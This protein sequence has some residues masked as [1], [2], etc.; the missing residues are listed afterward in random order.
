MDKVFWLHPNVIAGRTGPNK[1]FWEPKELAK[2]GIGAVLSVNSGEGANPG[3]LADA[4]IRYACVPLSDAAPP[5]PGDF[6]ICTAALPQ[7]L[8]FA[9]R[10]IDSGKSLL[11]HCTSGKDRTAMFLSYYLCKTEGLAP[12]EAIQAVKQVRPIALTAKG[13]EALTLQVLDALGA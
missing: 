6:A 3:D 12:A 2:G 4:G 10:S 5:Q 1:D 7:A 8:D 9:L 13:W 11:V